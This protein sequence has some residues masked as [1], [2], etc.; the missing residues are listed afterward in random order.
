MSDEAVRAKTG[1]TW[2]QWVRQLDAIGA[3][4]MP[5]REIAKQVYETNESSGWWAQMVTVGYE[6]IPAYRV[7]QE[8]GRGQP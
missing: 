8:T 3:V 7:G 6:R 1:R 4:R 2:K 5:H